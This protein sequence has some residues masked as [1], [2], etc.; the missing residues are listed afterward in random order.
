MRLKIAPSI[1]SADF[2][3][4]NDEIKSIEKEADLIHVDVMD[5]HFVPNLTIGAPVVKKIKSRRPLDCHLMIEHP[6]RYLEEFKEAGAKIIT[7]HAE[8]C[9]QNLRKTL[10]AI[11]QLKVKAGVSIKPATA[12][13]KIEA[14]LKEVDMV[15]LMTVNPG[16]G[17]QKFMKKVLPKIRQLRRISPGLDIQVDGGINAETAKE[18]IKA[19]ANVLVAGSYIFHAKNRLQAIRSLKK[20]KQS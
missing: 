5:G 7:V 12:L 17:G 14:V 9:G 20:A 16:F 19:G 11:K 1:L 6:E 18:V 8:A 15:L 13:K 3:R 2:G 4:L 10:R